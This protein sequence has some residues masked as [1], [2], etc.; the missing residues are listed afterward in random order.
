VIVS[1]VT[2]ARWISPCIS[3]NLT[4]ATSQARTRDTSTSV[5]VTGGCAALNSIVLIYM[6]AHGFIPMGNRPGTAAQAPPNVNR[7]TTQAHAQCCPN[8]AHARITSAPTFAHD[9]YQP[10]R[11]WRSL[12]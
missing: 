6:A 10:M 12:R 5:K 2:A 8:S 7:Q 9:H 1:S 4:R 3:P 11:K